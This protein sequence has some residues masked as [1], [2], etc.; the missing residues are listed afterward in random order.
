MSNNITFFW[1]IS[2]RLNGIYLYKFERFVFY[3]KAISYIVLNFKKPLKCIKLIKNKK[4]PF[5]LN[6]KNGSTIK[7]KNREGLS[8][9]LKKLDEKIFFEDKNLII[10]FQ[11][12]I[13]KFKYYKS[14]EIDIFLQ[15][16][17]SKLCVKNKILIDVGGNVGDSA[18]LFDTFEPKKIIMLEP[19]P[20][21]L[22]FAKENLKI[23]NY[24][25]SIE[26]INAALS[27]KSG[28]LKINYEKSGQDFKIIED[29]E[30]GIE[31]P[32]ITLQDIFL[33][34]NHDEFILKM[35]CEGCEYDVLLN[36]PDEDLN[37]FNAILLEFH[38]GFLN[39]SKRLE[40]LG[41]KVNIL[42]CKYTPEKTH[43][44]HLLALKKP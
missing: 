14:I 42:N 40:S 26:M 28:Y 35:D 7:I 38:E 36:S 33:N 17:Y 29:L 6:K 16:I 30:N 11:N 25:S 10:N 20:K 13:L 3:L 31:I 18:L 44:G 32:K 15:N 39:I 41:F 2:S 21:F 37:K 43:R 4:Y 23:N 5:V 9:V 1:N 34:Q 8:I 22:E 19:Q 27:N 24:F 12:K